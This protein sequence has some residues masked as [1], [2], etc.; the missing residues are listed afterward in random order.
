MPPSAVQQ[1]RYANDPDFQRRVEMMMVNFAV[2]QKNA[3]AAWWT[4]LG[5]SAGDKTLWLAL[6][7]EVISGQSALKAARMCLLLVNSSNLLAATWV[8]DDWGGISTD[9]TDANLRS[10]VE[11]LW[12]TLA[13][14]GSLTA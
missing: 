9:I 14:E 3:D 7:D 13:K 12:P 2:Y 4:G 11:T 10:Q 6:A 1:F 5:V 8:M